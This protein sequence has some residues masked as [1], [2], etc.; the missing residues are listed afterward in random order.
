MLL[1]YE[2]GQLL[3][4]LCVLRSPIYASGSEP[5]GSCLFAPTS[6]KD[7]PT[8][9]MFSG[10]GLGEGQGH[11]V[12]EQAKEGLV[13]WKLISAALHQQPDLFQDKC[14]S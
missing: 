9:A 11:N 5:S 7:S 3:H 2:P 6:H 1:V 14:A 8:S 13:G 10:R 12:Q 4:P